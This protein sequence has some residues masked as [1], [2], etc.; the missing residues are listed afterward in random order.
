MDTAPDFI[1]LTRL[2]PSRNMAR[3]YSLSIE[4]TLFGDYAV[5]RAWGRLGTFGQSRLDVFAEVNAANEHKRKL[6]TRK[7]RRGYALS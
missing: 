7:L 3:F 2:D 1:L 4:P 5:R 6:T